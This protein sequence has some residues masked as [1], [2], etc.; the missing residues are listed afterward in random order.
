MSGIDGLTEGRIVHFIAP[1]SS[2]HF[3]A[4]VIRVTDKERGAVS[5]FVFSLPHERPG[6]FS[7]ELDVLPGTEGRGWHWIEKA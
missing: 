4:I 5:L 6:G 2:L 7:V 3:A 1:Y